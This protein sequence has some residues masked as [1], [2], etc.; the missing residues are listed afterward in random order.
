MPT[1]EINAHLK[2]RNTSGDTTVIYPI[3]RADNIEGILPITSGGT[4]ASD[5]ATACANL[6]A[7]P[8]FTYSTDDILPGSTS[9]KADGTMH[10]VYTAKDGIWD[11]VRSVFITV[12]GVWRLVWNTPTTYSITTNLTNVTGASSNPT[13]IVEGESASLTFTAN[14]GYT[15]PDS[16]TVTGATYTWNKSTG[17]LTLSDPTGDVII[18]IAAEKIT[19]S[20]TTNLTNVTGASSNPTT[21]STGESASL[22]FTANSGYTLP[23]SVTVT[24][25]TYTWNKS[26]G[27][28]TLS[29]PTKNV[30]VIVKG[31]VKT[32]TYTTNINYYLDNSLVTTKTVTST[33]GYLT[34]TAYRTDES[35]ITIILSNNNTSSYT[36]DSTLDSVT[37][38]NSSSGVIDVYA[39]SVVSVDTY[40]P[41]GTYYGVDTPDLG[42]NKL[43]EKFAFKSDGTTFSAFVVDPSQYGFFYG[44]SWVYE[45]GS[46]WTNEAYR[47]ITLS[48]AATVSQEFYNWFTENYNEGYTTSI[49][50]M[51]G[52][53]DRVTTVFEEAANGHSPSVEM[54]IYA[55]RLVFRGETTESDYTLPADST[56]ISGLSHLYDQALPDEGYEVGATQTIVAKEGQNTNIMLYP[57][58]ATV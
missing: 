17:K 42:T 30:S 28:L 43:E 7:A 35:T 52:D 23:D 53:D 56:G 29:N 24:G 47:T 10:F 58:Y 25:A 50:L 13:T 21:I 16:V 39:V 54:T 20:I 49:A 37:Y 34:A 1:T 36:Y 3:T 5:A 8:A 33:S 18:R 40:I 15:L 55:D 6:G 32:T 9:E 38:R 19:Y 11:H 12:D 46:G 31:V 2:Y 4:G 51:H 22:T 26:T 48:T 14:S 57:V 44:D 27:K 45:E 41:A